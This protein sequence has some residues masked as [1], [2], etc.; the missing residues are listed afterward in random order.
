MTDTQPPHL[1][2]GPTPSGEIEDELPPSSAEDRKAAAALSAL[3][4]KDDGGEGGGKGG[5]GNDVDVE[6]VRKAMGRLG[7]GSGGG[8]GG[9]VGNGGKGEG[10]KK[11]VVKVEAGDVRVVIEECELSKPKATELLKANEGDL[12]RALRAFVSV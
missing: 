10:G 4:T 12:V 11:V 8:D 7:A 2:P 6:A 9:K 5:G 1:T 3:D